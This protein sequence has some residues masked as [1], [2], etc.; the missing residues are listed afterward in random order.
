MLNYG[1][2]PATPLKRLLAQDWKECKQNKVPRAQEFVQQMRDAHHKA[3]QC[4]KSA[5]QRQKAY[6]DQKRREVEFQ[7]GQKVWLSTK[8]ITLK[9]VGSPKFLPKFI[10]PFPISQKVN[11]VAY[12]LELPPCLRIHNVFHVSLLAEYHEN[13][14][15]QPAP[16]PIITEQGLEYEVETILNHRYRVSGGYWNKAKTKKIGRKR[17]TEYLIQWKG[18]QVED[19]TWEPEYNCRNCPEKVLEYWE[20]VKQKERLEQAEHA[21]KLQEKKLKRHRHRS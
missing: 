12:K 4:L 16:L 8:N 9:M 6:T 19:N 3:A 11:Q 17:T 10:G 20:A 18:Y 14:E 7:V 1:R 21:L 15:Q 13:S 5:Q 2:V